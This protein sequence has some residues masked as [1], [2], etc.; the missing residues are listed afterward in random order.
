MMPS[1]SND[2]DRIQSD[3]ERTRENLTAN[4]N[5]QKSNKQ[6]E[7]D[8]CLFEKGPKAAKRFNDLIAKTLKLQ[9]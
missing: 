3:D 5:P 6:V 4:Q 1:S 2:S 7:L 9:E 8:F